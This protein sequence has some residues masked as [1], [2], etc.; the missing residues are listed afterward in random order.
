M[1]NTITLFLVLLCINAFAA[2]A[3]TTTQ[4]PK[5]A[6]TANEAIDPNNKP[7]PKLGKDEY[8]IFYNDDYIVV[9]LKEYEKLDLTTNCFKKNKPNCMAYKVALE[10]AAPPKISYSQA[11]NLGAIYCENVGGRNLIGNDK[12]LRQSN[13]CRFKDGSM[14]T[15]WSMYFKQYPVPTLK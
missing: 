6:P 4:P 8:A 13:F 9:K 12:D 14:V 7:M 5:A 2:N 15:S 3:P 11:L 10:K 1:K